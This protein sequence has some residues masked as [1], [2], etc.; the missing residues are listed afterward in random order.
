MSKLLTIGVTE[1]SLFTD[2]CVSMI[3]EFFN[4]NPIKLCQN[5]TENI[6]ANLALCDAVIL[7]GGVDIHPSIYGESVTNNNNFTRFNI[8]RDFRELRIADYCL[9]NKVPLLGICRG[10]QMLGVYFGGSMVPDLGDSI[11]CHQP[12]SQQIQYERN[13]PMHSVDLTELWAEKK[14]EFGLAFEEPYQ[15]RGKK[16]ETTPKIWINSFHHQGIS[17]S[18]LKEV[19]DIS[20]L[21]IAPGNKGEDDIIELMYGK[22]WLS[23]QWHPEYD[24]NE[25]ANSRQV[26]DSFQRMIEARST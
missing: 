3:E 1:P 14:D 15:T 24:W 23:C 2:E 9:Q 7:A 8:E 19:D 4:A 13:S 26:L 20:I 6:Y 18:S 17:V 25:N 16:K 12:K 5:K 10:H 11:I 22:G 21:G